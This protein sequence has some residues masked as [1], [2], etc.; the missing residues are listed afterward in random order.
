MNTYLKK[1]EWEEP[2][3]HAVLHKLKEQKYIDDL[4]FAAAYVRTQVNGG[5]KDRG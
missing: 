2:V 4:E 1:K 3:I 5:K